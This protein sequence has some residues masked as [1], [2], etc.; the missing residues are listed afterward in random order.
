M[1]NSRWRIFFLD[2]HWF[3]VS[4]LGWKNSVSHNCHSSFLS[5]TNR[6][7]PLLLSNAIVS[8]YRAHPPPNATTPVTSMGLIHE[9]KHFPEKST[10]SIN[11]KLSFSILVFFI[12]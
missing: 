11:S 3:D 2:H 7:Q 6:P 4:S 5:S 12:Q 8:Q 10:P 9:N 1:P